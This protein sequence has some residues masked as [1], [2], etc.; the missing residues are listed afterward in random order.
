MNLPNLSSVEDKFLKLAQE[1]SRIRGLFDSLIQAKAECII[2]I[3]DANEFLETEDE[4]QDV[5]KTLHQQSVERTRILYEDV[6]TGL[7]KDIFP[8]DPENHRVHLNLSVKRGQ[9]ALS[10]EV[11]NIYGH[12][13]DVFLDKGG[14]VKSIIAIG[15]RFIALS[16]TNRRRFVAFDEADKELNPVFIPRFAKMMAQLASKIGMQVV[17]ISHHNYQDFEGHARIIK[18]SRKNGKVYSDIISDN[19]PKDFEGWEGEEH[20]ATILEGAGIT[21]ISLMNVKQ[22]QNTVIELSPLVNVIIGSNDIGKSTIVQALEC[23]ARNKG[24]NGLI[25]D[26]QDKMRIEIGLEGKLRLVYQYK[27]RGSRKTKYQLYNHAN[28]IIK[29]SREGTQCPDWLHGVLGMEMYKNQDLHIG[30]QGASNFMLDV[31]VSEHKR[32]EIL[33]L[34]KLCGSTQRMIERHNEMI[35]HHKKVR[36]ESRKRLAKTKQKLE[37]VESMGEFSEA[38]DQFSLELDRLKQKHRD[39]EKML[40]LLE[41][42]ETCQARIEEYGALKNLPAPVPMVDMEKVA[43][44]QGMQGLI[45]K[46]STLA[47]FIKLERQSLAQLSS[48]P[49]HQPVDLSYLDGMISLGK[50]W[51]YE[52]KMISLHKDA[53]NRLMSIPTHQEVRFDDSAKKHLDHMDGLRELIRKDEKE[54][55]SAKIRLTQLHGQLAELNGQSCPTCGGSMNFNGVHVHAK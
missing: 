23:V 24:R 19:A 25:R 52:E 7:V 43:Q 33:S 38:V 11:S 3:E 9:A 21:D 51:S 44:I 41:K 8:N 28:A 50:R 35:D 20:I 40:Q 27:R 1:S 12:R 10:V 34:N 22:H 17:Y 49:Q 6:L 5:L 45:D 31:N 30:L 46:I 37:I 29:E 53:L 13:R 55:E 18:L 42:W 15:L 2:D 14:S 16:R 47:K 26:E 39:L 4:V 36:N 48:I 54:I 32:A